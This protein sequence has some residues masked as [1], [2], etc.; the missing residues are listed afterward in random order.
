[1]PGISTSE[2]ASVEVLLGLLCFVILMAVVLAMVTVVGHGLWMMFAAMFGSAPREPKR[3]RHARR[4]DRACLGC[5]ETVSWDDERCPAC[6]LDPDSGAAD[7]LRD[8]E[9]TAR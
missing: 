7:E 8:L 2:G 1:M 6:G 4:G 5:G 3:E 9:A